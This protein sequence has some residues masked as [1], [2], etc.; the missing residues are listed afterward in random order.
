MMNKKIFAITGL[1]VLI[2]LLINYQNVSAHQGI[3]V[4]DYEL[5][6]GWVIE[7]PLVGQ[8]NGIVVNI[9]NANGDKALSEEDVIEALTVTIS[10][11][12]QSKLLTLQPLG[13]DTPG[14][15]V[16]PVLPAV[17]GQYLL[18]LGGKLGSTEID[19]QMVPEEVQSIEN[20]QFPSAENIQQ[21]SGIDWFP[22]LGVIPGFIGIGLSIIALRKTR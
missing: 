14:H 5:E 20:L 19:L 21:R 16:A 10:Y 3:T 22:W 18:I 6:T 13:E 9:S 17:A 2:I 12:G 1:T 8:Q 4:G 11:G 15:F 7:P